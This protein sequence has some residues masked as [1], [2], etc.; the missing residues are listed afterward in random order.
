MTSNLVFL[1]FT[2]LVLSKI[3]MYEMYVSLCLHLKK[4]G[5]RAQLCK[6]DGEII[7]KNSFV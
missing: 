5:D 3:E 2:I 4:Y 6:L 1:G 7:K